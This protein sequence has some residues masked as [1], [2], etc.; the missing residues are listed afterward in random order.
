MNVDMMDVSPTHAARPRLAWLTGLVCLAVFFC[1]LV[2][3]QAAQRSDPFEWLFGVRAF[4]AKPKEIPANVE[5]NWMRV[6]HAEQ[7]SPCLLR[8]TSCLSPADAPQWLSLA[9]KAAEMEEME[10][11]RTVNALFN[12]FPYASDIEN[13]GVEDRWPTMADFSSR[14]AGDCKAHTLAKYFA[15]HALGVPDERLRIVLVHLPRRKVNH[16]VLA[17]DTS[18]G[19]II[20]DG[21]V[22]PQALI[23]PQE[24][25]RSEFIPL[26]MLNARGR[27]TFKPDVELLRARCARN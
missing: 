19:V 17:V 5:K 9:A 1:L 8:S 4:P 12:S 25:L 27:W 2:S 22:R 21:N 11:L 3:A 24:A 14:R 15:L 10:L 16:A 26:F 13:Y 7:A 6:L 18:R 20:L 23:L